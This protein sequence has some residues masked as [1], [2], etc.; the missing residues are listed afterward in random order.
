NNAAALGVSP[1]FLDQYIAAARQ[2][3][4]LAVGNPNPRVSSVTYSLAANQEGEL[5]L[6][7]GTRGG[8]RFKHN[9]PADGEY[10]I[11][12]LDLSLSLYTATLE[13]E[14]TLVIMIDGKI[15]FR[16][17]VGGP[18]DQTLADRKGPAGR[19]E[20]MSRFTKIPV[21]VEAGVRDVV[22]AFIDR[23]HVESDENVAT[24]FGGVGALG[25]GA[26]NG[27]MPRLADGVEIV[28]PY[29]PTGV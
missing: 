16:K 24:G 14:S 10:R 9:F 11:N 29:N 1:A 27:R 2:I 5:P 26:G 20:I 3:A 18:A 12:V 6:P 21:R 7:P 13:N 28:G 25:F 4:K 19:E 8:M 22:V 17:P 15:V 23:S